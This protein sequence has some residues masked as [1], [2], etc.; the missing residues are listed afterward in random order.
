[1]HKVRSQPRCYRRKQPVA[2]GLAWLARQRTKKRGV[3][4]ASRRVYCNHYRIEPGPERHALTASIAS[5]RRDFGC[6]PT[7]RST[8]SPALKI[9]SVGMLLTP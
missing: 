4:R 9:I 3:T 5:C 8:T 7:K 1:M 6:T 2:A